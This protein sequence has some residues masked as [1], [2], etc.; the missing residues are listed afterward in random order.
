MSA[1]GVGLVGGI[2]LLVTGVA[3]IVAGTALGDPV[4]L[5]LG[6]LNLA[7]GF[8]MLKSTRFTEGE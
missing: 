4:G 8:C 5:V 1:R 3:C 2:G 7:G 6:L